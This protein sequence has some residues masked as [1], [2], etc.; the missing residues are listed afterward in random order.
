MYSHGILVHVLLML[1]A[2]GCAEQSD[3]QKILDMIHRIARDTAELMTDVKMLTYR[4]GVE[5]EKMQRQMDEQDAMLKNITSLLQQE[6]RYINFEPADL[7]VGNQ[8]CANT[9]NAVSGLTTISFPQSGSSRTVYCDQTIAEGGWVVFLRRMDAAEDFPNKLW[10]DYV[11]GFGNLTGSF[12]LGLQA[13]H[14]ITSRYNTTLRIQLQDWDGSTGYEEYQNFS[15]SGEDD[16]Y[17]LSIG[18]YSGDA[19]DC[20]SSNNGMQFSTK[21]KDQDTWSTGHC[22]TYINGPWWYKAC[23]NFSLLTGHYFADRGTHGDHGVYWSCWKGFY[24]SLKRAEMMLRIV[25]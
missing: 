19:G 14:E 1:C 18:G 2:S 22:S 16:G 25:Q 8:Y 11:T 12:W 13:I 21:D 4:Q 6:S 24:Y 9:E 10:Q 5:M 15:I 3:M 23:D 17:R 20:L 7:P